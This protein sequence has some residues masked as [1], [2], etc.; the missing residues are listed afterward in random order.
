VNDDGVREDGLCPAEPPANFASQL[1]CDR[2]AYHEGRH[3]NEGGA[4]GGKYVAMYKVNVFVHVD[5]EADDVTKVVVED[6]VTSDIEYIETDD[7]SRYVYWRGHPQTPEEA[8]EAAR[9]LDVVEGH[10]WP[11]WRLG[12]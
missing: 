12:N 7:G 5:T 8:K 10:E 11:Q 9:V 2:E 4:W 6:E 1:L 3:R